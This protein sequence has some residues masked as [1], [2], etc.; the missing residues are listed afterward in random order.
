MMIS[1]QVIGY[2]SRPLAFVI[3][4]DLGAAELE[5]KVLFWTQ[6]L[7]QVGVRN[8]FLLPTLAP[9]PCNTLHAGRCYKYK[10][11]EVKSYLE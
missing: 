7:A 8:D 6:A 5:D 3:C 2:E 4:S 11:N 1:M 9:T 10:E